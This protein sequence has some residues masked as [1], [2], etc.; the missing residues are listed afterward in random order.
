MN[1]VP[2]E[3]RAKRAAALAPLFAVL[4]ER[5]VK[6]SWFARQIGPSGITRNNLWQYEHGHARVPPQF[7][8]QACR[9][10]GIPAAF[11]RIPEPRDLY[12]QQPRNASA[13]SSPTKAKK[14]TTKRTATR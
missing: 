14:P 1:R 3:V 5:G 12:I 7:V 10:L 11:I 2:E 4:R 8:A 6:R 9:V 13:K